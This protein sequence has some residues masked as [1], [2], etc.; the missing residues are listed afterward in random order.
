MTDEN[1]TPAPEMA[2]AA[3]GNIRIFL[4]STSSTGFAD[5]ISLPAGST[6]KT[7]WERH[8]GTQDPR[9]Y[10]IRVE[11]HTGLLPEDFILEDGDRVTISPHKVAGAEAPG[12]LKA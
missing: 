12:F 1:T 4:T 3:D 8:M 2:P 9:K 11:R 10:V 5:Y 6:V 7:L